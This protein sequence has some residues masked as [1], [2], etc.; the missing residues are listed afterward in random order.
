M[1]FIILFDKTKENEKWDSSL[2][3]LMN[4]SNN[5]NIIYPEWI[6]V[7]ALFKKTKSYLLGM[8]QFGIVNPISLW[9]V[10]KW[11]PL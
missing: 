8:W 3:K 4:Y 5:P 2:K 1:Y 10:S 6:K 9:I 7:D 11:P